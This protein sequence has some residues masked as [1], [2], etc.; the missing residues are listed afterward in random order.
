MGRDDFRLA[1]D[2]D[3]VEEDVPAETQQ[4]LVVHTVQATC[5]RAIPEGCRRGR[6]AGAVP[7]RECRVRFVTS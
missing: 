3:F 7:R 2:S 4:L 5:I 6:R 1:F